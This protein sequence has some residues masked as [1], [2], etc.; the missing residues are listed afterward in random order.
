MSKRPRASGSTLS[1][2]CRA[3]T[4]TTTAESGTFS[5]NTHR[6]PAASTSQPPANGPTAPATPPRPD[7]APTARGRSS[8]ANDAWMIASEPGVSRAPP[9]PCSAR[10][11]IK[12]SMF[13]AM[14]HSTDATA[15]Q[16]TP[17]RK[18]RRRPNRSPRE[19]P[20]RMKPAS[21]SV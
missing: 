10:A 7:Q 13:G 17:T 15:N 18:M 1:G 19:P 12:V 2:T 16:T 5:R 8:A 14:P 11:R 21:V 4:S 6:Q 9:A 20:S 3:A